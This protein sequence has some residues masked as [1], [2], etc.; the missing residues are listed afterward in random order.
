MRRDEAIVQILASKFTVLALE[1]VEEGEIGV[2]QVKEVD[3]LRGDGL[4]IL[5]RVI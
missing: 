1:E 2:T 5:K 3:G 4:A